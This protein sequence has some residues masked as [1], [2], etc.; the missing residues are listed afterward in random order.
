M[1]LLI[2][3]SLALAGDLV[4]TSAAAVAVYVDGTHIPYAPG[5]LTAQ[6]TGL[7]GIHRVDIVGPR[8]Q[9][10]ASSNVSVPP[11]G[12]SQFLF[13]GVNL[14]NA[15]AGVGGPVV[16]PGVVI[17]PAPAPPPEP[18]GPIAMDPSA[19]SRL[20][21]SVRSAS[22][23][24]GKLA[25][26]QSAARGNHFTIRQVGE[27]LDLMDFDADKVKA[28]R[29]CAPKVVDPENAFDLGPHFDFDSD[30]QAALQL[31]H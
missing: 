15:T 14:V 31:F 17:Q 27:L 10:V 21:S 7:Q 1:L 26:I 19:F 9:V 16:V 6:V 11:V 29:I 4:V 28:V 20:L 2:A 3:S 5:T 18:Q 8:G 22:F 13:D 25:A 24:D 23:S 12:I 30:R